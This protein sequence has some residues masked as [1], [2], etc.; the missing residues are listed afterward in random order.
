MFSFYQ[1]RLLRKLIYTL[2]DLSKNNLH[3]IKYSNK[4]TYISNKCGT[5]RNRTCHVS[6]GLTYSISEINQRTRNRIYCPIGWPNSSFILGPYILKNFAGVAGLEPTSY[7]FGG[8]YV[9]PLHQT[10][11]YLN[12][13]PDAS[14]EFIVIYGSPYDP[15]KRLCSSY[16]SFTSFNY[17]N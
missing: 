12:E 14:K 8:R 3:I 16:K 9:Q 6:C 2:P 4:I 5:N 17:L 13:V 7:S 10:P 1:S 15:N 11:I